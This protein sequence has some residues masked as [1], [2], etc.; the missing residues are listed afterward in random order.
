MR[1]DGSE[2]P[3]QLISLMVRDEKGIP[4][5]F[6]TAC[7]DITERTRMQ[8]IILQSKLD[9]ED[10]FDTINDVITIHDMDFN[11]IRANKAAENMLGLSFMQIS[12]QKCFQAYHGTDC[13]KAGCPSCQ[14]LVTGEPSQM[15]IYEPHLGRYLEIKALPRF[16]KDNELVGL[17]HIVRDIS[18]HKEA[19]NRV[20]KMSLMT[21][22]ILDRAPFGVSVVNTRGM[23]EYVNQVMI[24]LSGA[25]NEMLSKVNVF[26]LP[27]LREMGV[28]DMIRSTF[29]GEPFILGP[30]EYT[31][32][33]EKKT[34]TRIFT[35]LPFEDR[36]VKKALVFVEDISKRAEAE[37]QQK[38]LE[39]EL[40]QV[41]KMDSIGRLAG[42]VAHDFNNILSA[43]IGYSELALLKIPK[44]SPAY[45][46]VKIVKD[47]GERAAA[48]THQLLAFSR[49][50]VL[51][52]EAVNLNAVIDNITK[53]LIRII[54]E[55]ITLELH[56]RSRIDSIM[57]DSRQIEQVLLNL[58]GCNASRRQSCY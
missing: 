25:S 4:R 6:V 47:S 21:H 1:K 40:L 50:Q 54:G 32:Y 52:M 37:R 15:E 10:T 34:V 12:G 13:P 30:V 36:G 46:S 29:E 31:S 28:S 17:V 22:E 3:V 24:D 26:E 2:F 51:R 20:R 44:D 43:I 56:A 39:S 18:K 23:I 8:D 55:D 19:E 16:G 42:G 53:M 14:T 38:K 49:K 9:W 48:L 58:A 7:E 35:G 33:Y 41:Q 11:I 57:A 45:E 5:G 27:P